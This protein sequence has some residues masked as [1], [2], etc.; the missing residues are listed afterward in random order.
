MCP[1]APPSHGAARPVSPLAASAPAA[2]AANDLP[3]RLATMLRLERQHASRDY[4]RSASKA[5]RRRGIARRAQVVRWTVLAAARLGFRRETAL[6]AVGYLDRF[7]G[8]DAPLAKTARGDDMKASR[9]YQRAALSCLYLAVKL[10]EPAT[11]DANSVS[12]LARGAHSPQEIAAGELEV[13]KALRWRVHGPT[14]GQFSDCIGEL[15]PSSARAVVHTKLG[16]LSRWQVERAAEDYACIILRPSTVAVAAALNALD[17]LSPRDLP[18]EEREGFVKGISEAFD[19]DVNAPLIQLTRGRLLLD[20]CSPG[21]TPASAD[22]PG[23][24]GHCPTARA[25]SPD[26]DASGDAAAVS[27]VCVGKTRLRVMEL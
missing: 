7:A 5:A 23:P 8:S 6:S 18:E 16:E 9:A 15:L 22:A 20:R 4:L 24:S 21:P 17:R 3:E 13:L 1:S 25:V 10:H 12:L 19:L 11:L 27:P 26:D 2:A 14:A